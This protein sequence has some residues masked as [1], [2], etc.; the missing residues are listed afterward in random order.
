MSGSCWVFLQDVR[1]ALPV[2][3]EWL[4]GP[5][6]CPGVFGRLTRMSES[7][8]EVLPNVR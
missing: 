8:Q 1:E 2:V 4:G 6:G 5:L 3:R 7:G